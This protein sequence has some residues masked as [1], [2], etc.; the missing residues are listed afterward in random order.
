MQTLRTR[1]LLSVCFCFFVSLAHAQNPV[2]TNRIDGKYITDWLILGPFKGQDL[3]TDFLS[4]SGGEAVT[5]PKEG[6]TVRS[7]ATTA[8][9]EILTWKRYESPTNLIDL[10]YALGSHD[11]AT[12]YAFSK[13]HSDQ[14][15]KV[16]FSI[17][18]DDGMVVFINGKKCYSAPRWT[19][20]QFDAD[21]F[22]ADLLAGENRCL[23]KIS[24][25]F[26]PE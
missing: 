14:A 24:T 20:Q 15:D 2:P 7:L 3:E 21:R 17:G 26:S 5:D 18:R 25:Y 13:L 1:R 11:N 8:D 22:D 10:R 6:D 16:V 9:G 23:I 12:A 19:P 4:A